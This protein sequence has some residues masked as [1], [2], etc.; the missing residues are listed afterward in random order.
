VISF[1]AIER[2]IAPSAV[3]AQNLDS[4]FH[5]TTT[6]GSSGGGKWLVQMHT[7]ISVKRAIVP[8]GCAGWTDVPE[9]VVGVKSTCRRRFRRAGLPILL[10]R[11][12]RGP[13]P[14]RGCIFHLAV[15]NHCNPRDRAKNKTTN[16]LRFFPPRPFGHL[17]KPGGNSMTQRSLNPQLLCCSRICRKSGSVVLLV[18]LSPGR[19]PAK[20]RTTCNRCSAQSTTAWGASAVEIRKPRP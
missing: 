16:P 19:S 14:L 5:A 7:E 1:I 12:L 10:C 13:R 17:D 9:W 18:L 2:I 20:N 8:N 11:A 15:K 6:W 4:N 3:S